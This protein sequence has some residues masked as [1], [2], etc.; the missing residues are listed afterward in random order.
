MYSGPINCARQL[1]RMS[2]EYM[3]QNLS[4][5]DEGLFVVGFI[6][7]GSGFVSIAMRYFPPWLLA[8]VA[9]LV[10]IGIPLVHPIDSTDADKQWSHLYNHEK[11]S[12]G[13]YDEQQEWLMKYF[14]STEH[15]Q[16]IKKFTD[17]LKAQL[18][19][20]DFLVK[21]R[22]AEHATWQVWGTVFAGTLG[23]LIGS[24]LTL[25]GTRIGGRSEP[26][27]ARSTR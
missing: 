8:I 5:W 26:Q 23:G 7:V 27:T 20:E 4:L 11:E 16:D 1:N 25:M 18:K 12:K 6:L 21:F 24:V 9:G 14:K 17:V 13:R 19:L 15:D 3:G 2:E 10:C 22:E